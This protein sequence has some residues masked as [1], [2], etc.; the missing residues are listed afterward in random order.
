V[1]AVVLG[2]LA[3]LAF[4]DGLRQMLDPLF[5][6][7]AHPVGV[8]FVAPGEPELR[9]LTCADDVVQVIV[10]RVGPNKL[11]FKPDAR[12]TDLGWRPLASSTVG[13][14]EVSLTHPSSSLHLR[15]GEALPTGRLRESVSVYLQVRV[16]HPDSFRRETSISQIDLDP[17]PPRGLI[18]TQKG[19][20]RGDGRDPGWDAIAQISFGCPPRR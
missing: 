9:V 1:I 4:L 12:A 11:I 6:A 17:P 15:S 2:Y 16:A 13:V 3:W 10:V 20:Y 8:T 14:V 19:S 18:K 7:S 5:N